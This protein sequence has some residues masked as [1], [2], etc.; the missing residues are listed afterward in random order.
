MDQKS[1]LKGDLKMP[2]KNPT[3]ARSPWKHSKSRICRNFG[4][5]LP[6]SN[7]VYCPLK[8]VTHQKATLL[9]FPTFYQTT[10]KGPSLSGILCQ[11][12]LILLGIMPILLMLKSAPKLLKS[13]RPVNLRLYTIILEF[14]RIPT[15]FSREWLPFSAWTRLI[16]IKRASI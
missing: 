5:K 16:M 6:K 2:K 11:V 14:K 9:N 15:P 8:A 4:P 13:L 10:F 7:L 3:L 1:A 12:S